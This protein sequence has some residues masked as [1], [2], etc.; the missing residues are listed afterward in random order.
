[1]DFTYQTRE[2]IHEN[3]AGTVYW[4]DDSYIYIC[5]NDVK[6]ACQT[7]TTEFIVAV[8][9]RFDYKVP[10]IIDRINHYSVDEESFTFTN[11]LA[12]LC[13]TSIAFVGYDAQGNWANKY[14]RDRF[15]TVVPSEVFSD[16][17][18][19][20]DWIKKNQFDAKTVISGQP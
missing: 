18:A 10:V 2:L 9:E 8:S 3:K 14:A 20:I 19:V 6:S 7:E 16:Q 1:L 4:L 15:S 17:D 13:F 11:E 5:I 12:P